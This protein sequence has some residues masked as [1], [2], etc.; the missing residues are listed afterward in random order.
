MLEEPP[1][2][3]LAGDYHELIEG[4]KARLIALGLT[5]EL[6]NER[7][8][9]PDRYVAKIEV[10][11]RSPAARNARALGQLSLPCI[12]GAL[13]VRLA[14]VPDNVC[15][16]PP[17]ATHAERGRLGGERRAKKLNAEERR[18]SAQ[19]AARVRWARR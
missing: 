7:A 14:I 10:S 2:I 19:R 13:R 1:V 5:Q 3:A 8:G 16:A 12:L 15:L 18:R 11:H 9:L 4:L 6:L 17:P